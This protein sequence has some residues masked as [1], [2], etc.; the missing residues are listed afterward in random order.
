MEKYLRYYWK[1]I[2][3]RLEKIN[4]LNKWN[5]S[6]LNKL[7]QFFHDEDGK[8]MHQKVNIFGIKQSLKFLY[9]C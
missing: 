4:L 9:L 6:L 3:F 7:V 2:I 8:I 1:I 5:K